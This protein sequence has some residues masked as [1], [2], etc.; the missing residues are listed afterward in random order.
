MWQVNKYLWLCLLFVALFIPLAHGLGWL[1]VE[2]GTAFLLLGAAVV[3]AAFRTYFGWVHGGNQG[4]RGWVFTVADLA[5]ISVGVHVTG[6]LESHIWPVYFLLLIAESLFSTSLQVTI[7]NLLIVSFYV[8]ATWADRHAPGY[9]AV[10]ATRMFFVV[11]VGSFG[12]RVSSDRERRNRELAHLQEEVAASEE[13]ARIA[14]EVHDSLGH[15]LV[16]SILRLELCARLVKRSPDEAEQML[17][18]EVP[19]LRAAWDEGRDLAFHLRPWDSEGV[20]LA[21]GLRRHIGR[22]AERT[23]L[24]VDVDLDGL[25][26]ALPKE[27]QLAITRV[28]QEALTNVAKHARA[29]RVSVKAERI[30]SRVCCLI[31]DDGDGFRVAEKEAGFGLRAMRERVERLGGSL[32]VV[33][34]PGEGTSVQLELPVT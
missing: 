11:M 8:A 1:T 10:V 34:Q 28:V 13:R 9:A 17:R 6:G 33:S 29:R 22:F 26:D 27:A 19:A 12:L 32:R 24:A 31:E 25:E 20:G 3:N 18:E 4:I 30:G 23:G 14:R 2:P 5:I 16:A 7:L 21:D 15:A